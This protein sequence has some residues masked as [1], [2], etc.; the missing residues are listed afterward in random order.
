MLRRTF[1][2][3]LAVIPTVLVAAGLFAIAR[4]VQHRDPTMYSVK[5]DDDL[6]DPLAFLILGCIGLFGC[7]KLWHPDALKK[8][9]L[10][11]IAAIIFAVAYPNFKY[12]HHGTAFNRSY[13]STL[14]HLASF[15]ATTSMKARERGQFVCASPPDDATNRSMF[16]R[17][18]Q[19][20]HYVVECMSDATGA[21]TGNPPERPGTIT[22]GRESRSKA[23]L[24]CRHG[25]IS[26]IRPQCCLAGTEW[27]SLCR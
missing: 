21:V 8:W 7:G 12:G 16:L 24:V 19:Q 4:T 22:Y 3:V 26:N 20:L 17:E 2:C 11:P 23:G 27:A 9:A 14:F 18:G 15:A 5:G 6:S 10:V 13:R 1:S 25:P